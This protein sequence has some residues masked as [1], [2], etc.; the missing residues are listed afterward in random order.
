MRGRDGENIEDTRIVLGL[1]ESVERDKAQTNRRLASDLGI[2]LGLT[3]A[4]LRRCIKKGLVKVQKTPASRYAYFVTPKGF[5]EKSR[6]TAK[7]LAYSFS[8]FRDARAE[9]VTCLCEAQQRGWR[10]IALAGRSDLAEI[11]TICAR[12]CGI[13]I[14]AVVDETIAG[15]QFMDTPVLS[16]LDLPG[17]IDGI[18][19]TDLNRPQ[20]AYDAILPVMGDG[21]ILLPRLLKVTRRARKGATL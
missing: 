16:H 6:L 14:A 9:C 12:E 17:N 2:A 13:E 20:D 1:L 8:F 7:Y 19:I 18:M 5:S 11:A 21:R 3:N 15:T 4:Y 10:S